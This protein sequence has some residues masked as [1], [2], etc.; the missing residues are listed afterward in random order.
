MLNYFVPAKHHMMIVNYMLVV[1]YILIIS[2]FILR[3]LRQKNQG[4]VSHGTANI[5]KEKIIV[6]LIKILAPSLSKTFSQTTLQML[7][8]FYV[9]IGIV[10]K[11]RFCY[12]MNLRI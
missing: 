4:K 6:N 11:T 10:T 5:A 8:K 3:V 12:E 2:G 9:A 7:Q 1:M